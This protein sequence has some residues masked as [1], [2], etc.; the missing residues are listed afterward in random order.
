MSI[1]LLIVEDEKN[2]KD[3]WL[4][5][6]DFYNIEEDKVFDIKATYCES[7]SE[8]KDLLLS[9]RFDAAIVDLRLKDESLPSSNNNV[10]G[11]EIVR[12]I[13]DSTMSIAAV[14]T[15]EPGLFNIDEYP[16]DSVTVF[17]KGHGDLK[18]ILEWIDSKESM[19]RLIKNMKSDINNEMAKVFLK[20]IW[21][22]WSFWIENSSDVY[23]VD[24]L[25]RHM[26]THLHAT[27][28][29]AG[30]NKVHPEEYFFI[31]PLTEDLDT[32]DILK[33][34]DGYYILVTPR[35][36]IAQDKHETLQLVFLHDE[37]SE[38]NKRQ[39]KKS[40]A[41]E[42]DKLNNAEES[43]RRFV[44]HNGNKS[45]CHFIP[46]F[47]VEKDAVVGPF[48]A[49]FNKITFVEKDNAEEI[50]RLKNAKVASLSNEFVPSLV[51]R[52]GGFFSRIGTPDYSHPE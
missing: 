48:F 52:L 12:L 42:K 7:L 11:V 8:A 24:A 19:I 43:I 17:E 37:S 28:L 31:P 29:N 23:T 51:E 35:C 46:Q 25:K 50:C 45:S 9:L 15:G 26:A 5:A 20:S 21:P 39:L 34:D 1:D 47:R 22:R 40:S 14:Y 49:K 44:N 36:E 6:I 27:F 10:D 3:S 16:K 33:M 32:G 13:S 4:R 41:T 38:W 30:S 18:V 2:I